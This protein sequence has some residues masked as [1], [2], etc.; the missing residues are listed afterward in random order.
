MY[1]YQP[2]L[3]KQKVKS[4]TGGPVFLKDY[5]PAHSDGNHNFRQ[6][7][8][9]EMSDTPIMPCRLKPPPTGARSAKRRSFLY[10]TFF[11]PVKKVIWLP[12]GTDDFVF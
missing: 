3:N 6:N 10:V 2:G 8:Q 4:R 12:A 7:E 1:F 5:S 11:R 9:E